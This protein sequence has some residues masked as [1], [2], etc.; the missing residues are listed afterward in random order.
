MIRAICFDNDPAEFYR[1]KLP[2]SFLTEP[3]DEDGEILFRY[4]CPSGSGHEGVLVVGN[5][6][7]P[8]G[9]GPTW[10][11]N[12]STSAATLNPS[13]NHVGHWHGWLRGGYWES[14]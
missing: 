1:R 11:W 4:F 3:P 14:V 5:R 13:V 8:E 9:P 10:H 7:K 12:G 6:F 2:G